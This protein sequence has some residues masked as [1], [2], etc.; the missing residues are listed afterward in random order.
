MDLKSIRFG[1]ELEV[2]RITRETAA[3]AIQSVVGGEV[4]HVGIPS[5]FDPWEVTDRRGRI[6][7]VVADASL[8]SVPFNLRA[9]IVSPILEYSD[10]QELQ[11]IVRAVREAGGKADELCG[12][13]V[14]IDAAPFDAKSLSN[15]VKIV[16]KQEDL[17]VKALD[18]A[19]HRLARYTKKLPAEI[20]E[21]INKTRPRTKDDLNRIWYGYYNANPVH[22]SP[23]RYFGLSLH[24]V[25]YRNTVELRWFKMRGPKGGLHAGQ[26]KAYIQFC[27]ALG[28]KAINNR[29]ASSRKRTVN[30][31]SSKYDFRVFLLGLSLSGD[32]FKAARQHLLA[33]LEGDSAFKNGRPQA[34]QAA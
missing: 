23:E 33:N 19:P 25:W 28:A 16:Y 20:I 24:N 18:I 27:L 31:I 11:D 21:K 10:I 34:E 15:L 13:H 22:Y 26:V 30:P 5:N 4:R 12:Q 17:I 7:K 9:E 32:E 8:S 1:T 14:H 29:A 6:W 3:R 2:I